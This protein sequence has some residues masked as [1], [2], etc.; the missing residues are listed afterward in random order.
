MRTQDC[1]RAVA[2]SKFDIAQHKTRIIELERRD[3]G[4]EPKETYQ[5]EI[6]GHQDEIR[7]IKHQI[8]RLQ[9][10]ENTFIPFAGEVIITIYIT[11]KEKQKRILFN[12]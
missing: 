5:R 3:E 8:E 12:N 6:Q 10:I 1:E 11:T 7:K 9:N 4:N 2:E